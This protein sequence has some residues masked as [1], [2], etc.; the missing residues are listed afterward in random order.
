[1][2]RLRGHIGATKEAQ[3]VFA[4]TVPIRIVVVLFGGRAASIVGVHIVAHICV[5]AVVQRNRRKGHWSRQVTNGIAIGIVVDQD[6]AAVLWVLTV[7]TRTI[8][9]V[10]A[11]VGTNVV[12]KNARTV[13]QRRSRFEIT[14]QLAHAART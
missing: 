13:V 1:M 2:G 8:Q 6:A 4:Q 9:R 3:R 5:I 11:A 10:P 7:D 12:G 14:R